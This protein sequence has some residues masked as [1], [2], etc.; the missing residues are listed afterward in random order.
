M[1]RNFLLLLLAVLVIDVHA[2]EPI[3]PPPKRKPFGRA[4][5]EFPSMEHRENSMPSPMLAALK[6]VTP[7]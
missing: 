7:R 5:S 2:R 3:S 1:K 4:I 6:S